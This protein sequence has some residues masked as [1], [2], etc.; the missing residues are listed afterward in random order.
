MY[1]YEFNFVIS[2]KEKSSQETRQRWAIIYIST[3]SELYIIFNLKIRF[4]SQI[5]FF[6][7]KQEKNITFSV[8]YEFKL[9]KK[10]V[11]QLLS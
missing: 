3:S 10:Q 4:V 1:V 6:C 7:L 2:T 5:G 8:Y 11:C 9:F